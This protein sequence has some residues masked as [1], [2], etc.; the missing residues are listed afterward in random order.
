MVAV[1]GA[2]FLRYDMRL[3]PVNVRGVVLVALVAGLTQVVVGYAFGLY[4]RGFRYGSFDEMRRLAPAMGVTAL[5]AFIVVAL[6]GGSLVPRSVPVLAL[7]L[8]LVIASVWRFLQRLHED[9]LL[10][11]RA[12]GSE[13]LVIIGAGRAGTNLVRSMVRSPDSPY[14]PVA[15]LDDDPN[16]RQLHFGASAWSG[17]HPTRFQSSVAS[18]PVPCS[19]QF[20]ARRTSD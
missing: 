10:R 11:P 17:R 13:P 18:G 5:V 16:K 4:R 20:R 6:D 12:D 2:T 8:A 9:T 7:F 14:R 15:L 1:F 19:S 3:A